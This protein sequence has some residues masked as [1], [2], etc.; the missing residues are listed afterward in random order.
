MSV[1]IRIT[2]N[3]GDLQVGDVIDAIEIDEDGDARV[4][5]KDKY[6]LDRTDSS[7]DR[8][9]VFGNEFEVVDDSAQRI[10]E[11]EAEVARLR[12]LVPTVDQLPQEIGVW[13]SGGRYYVRLGEDNWLYASP[14]EVVR[15]TDAEMV[16]GTRDS[17][18]V[19]RIGEK[20]S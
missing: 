18:G 14:Y 7:Y 17:Q 2:Q 11:L 15:R 16:S 20:I 4:Y 13:K 5:E 19:P 3:T 12:K 1:R 6:Q 8:E 10:E 9:W